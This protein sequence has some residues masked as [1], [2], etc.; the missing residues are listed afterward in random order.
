MQLGEPSWTSKHCSCYA[1]LCIRTEWHCC[2]IILPDE[3]TLSASY[4]WFIPRSVQFRFSL[5]ISSLW[6]STWL[7]SFIIVV[8]IIPGFTQC[9]VVNK[10][11]K[12]KTANSVI[13]GQQDSRLEVAKA[14]RSMQVDFHRTLYLQHSVGLVH[15]KVWCNI[16][17]L[18]GS[19]DGQITVYICCPV[20]TQLIVD[21]WCNFF[22]MRLATDA[23]FGFFFGQNLIT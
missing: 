11:S 4:A 20:S 22:V 8:I 10:T 21:V 16:C 2:I 18:P 5:N 7:P 17:L 3:W 12:L 9:S 19:T 15:M 1:A 6:E 13:A 14:L 23:L